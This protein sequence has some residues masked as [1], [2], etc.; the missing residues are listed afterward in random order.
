MNV[1]LAPAAEP[2]CAAGP[3][4]PLVDYNAGQG[5]LNRSWHR[6]R[7]AQRS[8]SAMTVPLL[9]IAYDPAAAPAAAAAAIAA[10]ACWSCACEPCPRTEIRCVGA[11]MPYPFSGLLHWMSP[12][13]G[14]RQ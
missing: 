7:V 10:A 6:V 1:P 4:L 11:P 12:V 8:A 5:G 13:S 3:H 2:M 14:S 9:G